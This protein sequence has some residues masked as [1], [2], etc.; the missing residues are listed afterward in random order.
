MTTRRLIDQQ[1]GEIEYRKRGRQKTIRI[2][3]KPDLIC[4][5]LPAYL[6]YKL[7]EEFVAS[8]RAWLKRHRLRHQ[9]LS[10]GLTIGK[11]H[12][13]KLV[14]GSQ[15]ELKHKLITSPPDQATIR[16]GVQRALA[17][18]AKQLLPK[19]AGWL[20]K[21]TG[22]EPSAWRFRQMETRWG[23]CSSQGRISL[24]TRLMQLPWPLI[25]YV[26]IHELCHLKHLNHSPKFWELVEAHQ[27]N[28]QRLRQQLR[29]QRAVLTQV[30]EPE[31]DKL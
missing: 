22:L 19:R 28:Y 14:A 18:E 8:R 4:V 16:R 30:D 12:R 2:R 23:S 6:P 7:A 21:T 20:V 27:P 24:N 25:D 29:A 26:I 11:Q 3:L 17:Q 5:S 1:L 10:D 9:H 31:V 15:L 13:L